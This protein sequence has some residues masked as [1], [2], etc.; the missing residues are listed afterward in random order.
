MKRPRR[1][2][3][4]TGEAA[5]STATRGFLR[6]RMQDPE[7]LRWAAR[8]NA[9][10]EGERRAVREAV[11]Y[12][13][14]DIPE[15]WRSAWR[16]VLQSWGQEE[17]NIEMSVFDLERQIGRGQDPHLLIGEIA[18]LV[19]PRLRVP[20][21]YGRFRPQRRRRRPPT[22]VQ[23]VLTLS[24]GSER[25]TTLG[26]LGLAGCD[27]ASVFD[28]LVERLDGTLKQWLQVSDRLDQ[29]WLA[30]WVSRVYPADE[31]GGDGDNDPD[32]FREGFAPIARLYSE[33]LARLA[34]LDAVAARR[35]LET[36]DR[37]P[38]KLTRRLWATA[39]RS[40]ALVPVGEIKVW[41]T[42]LDDDQLWDVFD[43][44][45]LAE[46][47]VTRFA[48]L[49]EACRLAFEARVRKG[50]R[51]SL[52]SRQV[53]SERRRQAQRHA[54]T[55]EMRRLAETEVGISAASQQ[56]L[57]QRADVT[58]PT[59]VLSL[60][61]H[62]YV[63]EDEG[64]SAPTTM[65][66][67]LPE[68]IE[69]VLAGK[70][71]AERHSDNRL[72]ALHLKTLLERLADDP[73]MKTRG[74]VIG[75]MALAL[76][77][78]PGDADADER[79]E[80][81]RRFLDLVVGLSDDVLAR[82][83]DGLAYWI[84]GI[85]SPLRDEEIF[86]TFWL[87][88]W[89]LAAAATNRSPHSQERDPERLSSNAFN[90]ATGRMLSSFMDMLPRAQPGDRV[91]D[92]RQLALMRERIRDADGEAGRQGLYRLLLA[93]GYLD[94]VDPEGTARRLLDPLVGEDADPAPWDAVSRIGLLRDKA[95]QRIA[96]T[97]IRRVY[98]ERLSAGVRARLAE[99]A[100]LP[101]VFALKQGEAAPIGLA[102]IGQMLR[103]GG[104]QV[105]STCASALRRVLEDS[106][107]AG[108]YQRF[109]KPLIVGAWPKD[110]STLSSGMSDALAALPAAAREAFVECVADIEGLLTPFDAWSLSEYR[111]YARDDGAEERS[112]RY[113]T[114]SEEA[115]A[116]L[117]LLDLTIGAEE[118]A[119]YPREL[120]VALQAIAAH[121]KP[122]TR[123]A[124][125]ARLT[126]L[127]RR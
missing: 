86:R 49:D 91:F 123:T 45:E 97:L 71:P 37:H 106:Q 33:A 13:P 73:E 113:P 20:P 29:A 103:L 78:R 126:A 63:P 1:R 46:L 44:P 17:D 47:R 28:D 65:D 16:Y 79:L 68:N 48:E 88:V 21:D 124:E 11:R 93:L 89:P 111:L 41:L 83:A 39:A 15:P 19:A 76:R 115:Q 42:G 30:N 2:F 98:D 87:R 127:T 9:N 54:A 92:D 62:T 58:G 105:R 117:R 81:D 53:S 10:E 107:D 102:D 14:V 23:H 112:L 40:P 77:D 26:D 55:M 119:I 22:H 118:G 56:W 110:R 69:R 4:E 18:D 5:V 36:L 125:F 116:L 95:L 114:S 61:T 50:P 67:D 84:G 3:L 101:T 25:L 7:V 35:R 60:Y 43:Y 72:V 75:A 108:A 121:S 82:A 27:Q 6:T 104:D 52:Y 70:T 38:W 122:A 31:D 66:P 64:A 8:L 109:I 99:R 12:A 32:Q 24:F 120:D 59:D 34:A 90:S 100:M 51:L 96:P 57:A 74:Y 85:G 80:E 94:F